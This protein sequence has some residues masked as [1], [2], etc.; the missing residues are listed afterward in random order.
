MTIFMSFL[1]TFN[2]QNDSELYGR[3]LR[4]NAAKPL[5]LKESSTRP[6][7]ADDALRVITTSGRGT[8]EAAPDM[9]T[10][11]LGVT[12]Q[13]RLAGEAMKGQSVLWTDRFPEITFESNE[14]RRDGEGGA[15]VTGMLTVRGETRPQTFRARLFRPP[16]TAAGDRDRLTIR[17]DGSLSRSAFG[18]SGYANFVGDEV[19]LDI[20]AFIVR[21]E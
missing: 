3:T 15:T 21:G 17:L 6:V 11:S 12:H 14:V 19:D 7:W 4:V 2:F 8:V 1:R 20:Q 13:A 10:I 16:G 9:A 5:R 18:A